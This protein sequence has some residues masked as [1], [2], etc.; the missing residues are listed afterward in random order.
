MNENDKIE[1]YRWEIDVENE[2]EWPVISDIEWPDN[3]LDDLI[4]YYIDDNQS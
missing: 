3:A 2:Q 4:T 1:D